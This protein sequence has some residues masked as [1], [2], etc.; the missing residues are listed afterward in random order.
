L[1]LLQFFFYAVPRFLKKGGNLF[2][3]ITKSVLNGDHCYKFRAFSL[4]N[5]IEIWDFPST[6]IFNIPN[7]CLKAEYIGKSDF[8]NINNKYPIKTKLFDENLKLKEETFYS[9]LKI[10][11]KGA[12]IIIPIHQ[13]K[14]LQ[15]ISYSPYKNK[16]HQGAT[17]VPRT[18]VFF[19]MN[20]NDESVYTLTSDPEILSKAKKKWK[21]KITDREIE[22][23][24]K[25]KS[26]LNKDLV[27]F[28]L[29]KKKRIFLPVN[30]EFKHDP[31]Y[32]ENYPKAMNLYSE[33]NKIYQN[34]KKNT[35]NI[36]TLFSNLNYW[37][38]LTKQIKNS[39]FIVI[40]N[41][42]GSRLKSAVIK[43][44]KKKIIIPSENYYYSTGNKEEAF[45]L[46][47]IL[48]SP[49]LSNSIKLIKS[50]RHIHKRPFN[51]PI[52]QY[53]ETNEDHV[54]LSKIGKKFHDA[55]QDIVNNNPRINADKVRMLIN[56]RLEELN[57]IV[58]E[59]L[60]K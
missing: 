6:N 27:P 60:F 9:S 38:K 52:P 24:F 25:F 20:K 34:N 58:E 47:A 11:K 35:S 54:T 19:N 29:K 31:H 12:K 23:Q 42:S 30:N 40:Y 28:C 49:I 33:L 41:A 36:N 44:F 56:K 2:L 55:V 21:F 37:N 10:E 3:I 43:N 46:S 57:L 39:H 13:L 4:F 51:F 18:L 17:L 50:S 26:Y 1:N 32:L 45:Y 14:L 7:I 8:V 48:N 59:V 16:F 53:D 5:N 15:K 22:T